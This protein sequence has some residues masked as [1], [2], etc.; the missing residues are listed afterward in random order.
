VVTSIDALSGEFKEARALVASEQTALLT[1][2][3]GELEERISGLTR[4]LPRRGGTLRIRPGIA[5]ISRHWVWKPCDQS[6]SPYYP[7]RLVS[8]G[9]VRLYVR[10]DGRVFDR[11]T[12]SGRGI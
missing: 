7:F 2:D 12:V 1:L 5:C 8:Y 4:D 9:D 11:L 6:L 3:R 10:S